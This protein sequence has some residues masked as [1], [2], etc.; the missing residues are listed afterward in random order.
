MR[1][2]NSYLNLIP[3]NNTGKYSRTSNV[4]RDMFFDYLNKNNINAIVRKEH[5]SD[6]DAACGQLRVKKMK[7]SN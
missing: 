1:G 3:Y 5:G 4:K 6:I 7:E 2:T